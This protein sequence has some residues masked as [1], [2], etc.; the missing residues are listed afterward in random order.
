MVYQHNG[1]LGIGI[2]LTKDVFGVVSIF[3]K[4]V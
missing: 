1:A 2:V 4:L 3:V